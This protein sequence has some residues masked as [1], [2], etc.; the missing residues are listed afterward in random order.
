M[1]RRH[2]WFI[3]ASSSSGVRPA[4][5]S[6]KTNRG[7]PAAKPSSSSGGRQPSS[8]MLSR[9]WVWAW[10]TSSG[11]ASLSRGMRSSAMAALMVSGPQR[12]TT[13]GAPT[14]TPNAPAALTCSASGRSQAPMSSASQSIVGPSGR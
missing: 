1:L 4:I 3:P 6:W 10:L 8:R 11:I 14:R 13:T 9:R 12:R 2:S 7:C 5:G